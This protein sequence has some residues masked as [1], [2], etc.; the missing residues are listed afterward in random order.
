MECQAEGAAPLPT[1]SS[2]SVQA[3]F[4]LF[5][6]AVLLPWNCILSAMAYLENV[7]FPG[8]HWTLIVTPGYNSL[9]LTSQA[10]MLFVGECFTPWKLLGVSSVFGAICCMLVMLSVSPLVSSPSGSFSGALAGSLGLAVFAGGGLQSSASQMASQ[11]MKE[12]GPCPAQFSNGLAAG[13]VLSLTVASV[14]TALSSQEWATEFLFLVSAATCCACIVPLVQFLRTGTI[15][16]VKEVLV[17]DG[18]SALT[19]PTNSTESISLTPALFLD[20]NEGPASPPAVGP[21]SPPLRKDNLT[22]ITNARIQ[23]PVNLNTPNSPRS[24]YSRASSGDIPRRRSSIARVSSGVVSAWKTEVNLCSIYIQTFL[25]F[26]ALTL[27]W[28]P[29]DVAMS[30]EDYGLALV[31]VFQAFDLVG[32]LLCTSPKLIRWFPPGDKVWIC[33]LLRTLLMPFFFVCWLHPVS[34]F[35][36]CALRMALVGLLA[37]SN[38]I[39]TNLS[40]IHGTALCELAQR[41]IIGRALP[42]FLG[43]G[44]VIGTALSSSAIAVLSAMPQENLSH[45]QNSTLSISF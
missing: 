26:P 11:L 39:L 4:F 20:V 19:T 43:L 31:S 24:V 33:V 45:L 13:G 29:N 41:D 34:I 14:V 44:I 6:T 30:Q 2:A 18:Q 36:T 37:L 15:P 1:M 16:M 27:K 7:A 17:E 35:R 3:S 42:L 40:F 12:H 9:A 23:S 5:G 22:N 10:L 21:C 25:V 32:R 28:E 38:G 8:Y